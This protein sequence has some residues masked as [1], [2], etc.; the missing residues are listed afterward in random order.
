[1]TTSSATVSEVELFIVLVA[2]HLC[3]IVAA[4]IEK[5]IKQVLTHG[6]LGGNFAGPQAA[7]QLD[8]A[9]GFRLRRILGERLPDDLI[10][11]EQV[12][13]RAVGAEAQSAE[14]HGDAELLFSV[15]ADVKG[16]LS[17]LLELQPRAAV[18]HDRGGEHFLARLVLGGGI[19]HPGRTHELG[20]DNALRAVDDEGTVFR[21]QRQVAHEYFLVENLVFDLVDEADFYAQRQS[22]SSVAVAALFFVVL[23]F[24]AESVLQKVELEMVGVVGDRGKILENLAD[25]FLNE[26][27]VAVLLNFDEIGN[28]DHFVDGA[29]FSSFIFAILVDR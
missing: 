15:H 27:I 22:V 24:I 1:M 13:Y 5:Q 18:G 16:V 14:Q 21:H 10:A 19:I 7:V 9:V 17:V 26:R 8:Q 25:T 20:D 12:L 3:D 11:G 6:I 4:G 23:G 2:P 29:E 28:I